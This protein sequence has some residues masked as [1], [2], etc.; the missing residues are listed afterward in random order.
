MYDGKRHERGAKRPSYT[1]SSIHPPNASNERLECTNN[2]CT[3]WLVDKDSKRV[4][5]LRTRQV[6][7]LIVGGF[8]PLFVCVPFTYMRL[9]LEGAF[10]G[11]KTE[12]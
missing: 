11:A 9:H 2:A 5:R 6:L 1:H 8:G 12:V 4:S 7:C 3:A 10:G